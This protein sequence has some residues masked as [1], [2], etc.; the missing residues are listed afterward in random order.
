MTLIRISDDQLMS[1]STDKNPTTVIKNG[2]FTF[3]ERDR[4]N[5]TNNYEREIQRADRER[6]V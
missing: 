6:T 4:H 1:E 5:T 3:Y 2:R